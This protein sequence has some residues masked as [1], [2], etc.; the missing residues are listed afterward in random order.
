MGQTLNMQGPMV[1]VPWAAWEI[2]ER[3]WNVMLMT[4]MLE[5]F[6]NYRVDMKSEVEEPESFDPPVEIPDA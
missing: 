3:L 5:D 1:A 6:L 4:G 2:R